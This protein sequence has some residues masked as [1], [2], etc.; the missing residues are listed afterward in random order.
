MSWFEQRAE[1]TAWF[2]KR[3]E[4]C[5]W[6]Q[7]HGFKAPCD[8]RKCTP[9]VLLRDGTIT[10]IEQVEALKR[11]VYG[12]RAPFVYGGINPIW[13]NYGYARAM[14]EKDIIA[15]Y[16]LFGRVIAKEIKND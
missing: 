12:A 5:L 2:D 3:I 10:K 13:D 7:G 16:G 6:S 11:D 14:P 8:C 1:I 15:I 4:K 9:K